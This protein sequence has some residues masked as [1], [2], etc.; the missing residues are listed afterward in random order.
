MKP[1]QRLKWLSKALQK[2]QEGGFQT[3]VLYD[4]ATHAKFP[5]DASDKIV[6]KMYRA[7]RA[8]LPLFSAKQVRYLQ[9]EEFRLAQMFQEAMRGRERAD[10]PQDD[11]G[12]AESPASERSAD[13]GAAGADVA[14]LWGRI[15]QLA[16]E[17]QA[18]AVGGLDAATK[19][20][21]E[22]FLVARITR[23]KE[24][25]ASGAPSDAPGSAA[26]A[27]GR[28]GSPP[29]GR[30]G[31]PRG[32]S[33]SG[34]G[35]GGRG[36]GGRKAPGGRN[37]GPQA[38]LCEAWAAAHRRRGAR[39]RS[40]APRRAEKRRGRPGRADAAARACTAAL[41]PE[42]LRAHLHR[43]SPR[44][45]GVLSGRLPPPAVSCPAA[46]DLPRPLTTLFLPRLP[47]KKQTGIHMFSELQAEF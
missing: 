10:D 1:E 15:S 43:T 18:A 44:M 39:V 11:K 2:C 28:G 4:I 24:G 7:L 3:T 21:L 5:N 22:E 46:A 9:S 23:R 29:R 19:E 36:R 12:R 8:N 33:S 27:A 41:A 16:A 14:S 13:G 40:A 38:A 45:R 30:S 26:G 42:R 25:A 6:Q 17:E 37:T 20:R 32:R 31:S 34:G 35:R 47:W